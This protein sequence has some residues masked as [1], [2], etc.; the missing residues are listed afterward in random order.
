MKSKR[1]ARLRRFSSPPD[2]RG[3]GY[4]FTCSLAVHAVSCST[5][6]QMSLQS[7]LAIPTFQ[8]GAADSHSRAASRSPN[9]LAVSLFPLASPQDQEPSSLSA[10]AAPSS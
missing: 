5:Q 3:T 4:F 9:L 1:S 8:T 2:K 10:A 6:D 7:S